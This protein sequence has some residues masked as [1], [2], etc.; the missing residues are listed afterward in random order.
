M[1][2]ETLKEE[3]RYIAQWLDELL[4]Q[5]RINTFMCKTLMQMSIKVAENVAIKY[6]KIMKGVKEIMGGRILEYEAKTI[7]REGLSQG[8]IQGACQNLIHNVDNVMKNLGWPLDEACRVVG[9]SSEEY[10]RAKETLR[11]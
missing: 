11:E 8:V 4:G 10:Q 9:S 6:D 1:K 7:L 3:Y 5:G 2:L